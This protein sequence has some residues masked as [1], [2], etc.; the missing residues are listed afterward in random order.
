MYEIEITNSQD[1]LELDEELLREVARRTLED[2][3]VAEAFVGVA[4]VDNATIRRLNREYLDHG[5]DTDVLSFLLE[6]EV[7]DPAARAAAEA[8]GSNL[9][10]AGRR[11]EGEVIVSTEMAV[12]RAA[13]FDWSPGDETLLYLV[14]GLLHLIGY[15]DLS[16]A[17]KQQMRSRERALLK[18]WNLVPR[19]GGDARTPARSRSP[20]GE[21]GVDP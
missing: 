1:L 12:E 5:F 7:L 8:E 15:D 10:G 13:E 11:I 4:L 20:G 14:H 6:S 18:R 2:E 21:G 3:R 19:Y 9:R 17:E 16:D